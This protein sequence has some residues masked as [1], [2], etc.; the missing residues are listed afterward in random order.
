MEVPNLSTT[1]EAEEIIFTMEETEEDPFFFKH[2][3][4]LPYRQEVCSFFWGGLE[5]WI[6]GDGDGMGGGSLG[7]WCFGVV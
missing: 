7:R 1:F 5:M 2:D 6:G 4:L 3:S